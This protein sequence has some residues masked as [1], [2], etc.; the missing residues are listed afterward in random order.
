MTRNLPIPNFIAGQWVPAGT[1]GVLAVSDPAP[2]ETLGHTPWSGRADVGL[3]VE[4]ALRAFPAWRATPAVERARVL[5]R[6]K[7][8]L[9]R[10]KE[11]LARSLTREHGKIVPEAR[12]GA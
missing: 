12:G 8:L 9:E 6:L 3:A 2:G 11:D 1:D 4:A 7:A 10:D 5:F